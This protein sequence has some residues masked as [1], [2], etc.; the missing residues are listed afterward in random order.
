MLV[1]VSVTVDSH[2]VESI[3]PVFADLSVF[4]YRPV[5]CFTIYDVYCL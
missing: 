5:H 4:F 3:R 1:T 2:S